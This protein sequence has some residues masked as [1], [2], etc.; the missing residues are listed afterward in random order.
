M[1][2]RLDR[3]AF[4][5]NTAARDRCVQGGQGKQY[6]HSIEILAYNHGLIEY[7]EISLNL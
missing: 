4:F 3:E 6:G 5:A 7:N 2:E 1:V